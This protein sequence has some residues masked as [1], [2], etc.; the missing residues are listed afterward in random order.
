MWKSL[1]IICVLLFTQ[2][3]TMALDEAQIAKE[4]SIQNRIDDIGARL[5]NANKIENR[6]VFVYDE[7]EKKSRLEIDPEVT[8][9]QI[10]LYKGDYNFIENDDELAAYLARG[11]L[12][13]SKSY[14]GL[15]N[16]YLSAFE[17]KAAPKKFELA[18]DKRAVDFMVNA[19]Y[20]PV[21]LITFIQKSCP[22]KRFD[23]I[24]TKN[25]ASRRLAMIYEYIYMKYPYYLQNNTY[26]NNEH[27]QNFLL[28][29]QENRRMLL[30]K[31]KTNS[32]EKIYAF[33]GVELSQSDFLLLKKTTYAEAGIC[34][35]AT[36]RAVAGTILARAAENGQ[37]IS[38]VV[39]A[40]GQFSCA[41]G[42]QVYLVT[43]NGNIEVT[44]EMAEK[45]ATAVMTAITDGSGLASGLGGEPLF[46][47]SA[48]GLSVEEL[49][50]RSTI[51]NSIT[52]DRMT[53]YRV[54]D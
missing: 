54:W 7:A 36:Q 25:L 27:Y 16:G 15:F 38:E 32:D 52:L 53:F 28:S 19:G 21:G 33:N 22:Q 26:L 29:S 49:A 2:S 14:R 35:E 23:T 3:C 45:T 13:A 1:F 11:I 34:D 40:P 31:I 6:V 20:H 37:T 4:Q 8:R 24:S 17:L 18:A 50:K 9:R 10:V 5:L 47:Y 48:G 44:Q 12:I 30:Q 42:G 41:I 43:S 39:F 46:F 51:S